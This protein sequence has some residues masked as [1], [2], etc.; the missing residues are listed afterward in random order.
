MAWPSNSS[1][2]SWDKTALTIGRSVDPILWPMLCAKSQLLDRVQKD[3][4]ENDYFEWE[5]A[6]TNARTFTATSA[7]AASS[8]SGTGI[9][10]AGGVSQ[11]QVGAIIRNSS[12]ATPIGTYLVDEI[13]QV[14]ANSGTA[15]TVT[16]DYAQQNAGSG[17]SA[18]VG[19]DTF[20]VLYTPKEEG[21]SPNVNKYKDVSITG[22]YTN[23]LDFYLTVTGTQ[24]HSK[25]MIAADNMARQFADR[26][27]ELTFDMESMAI[28]GALNNGANA[29][30]TSYV[31]TTKGLVNF[32]AVAGGNVDYTTK[33]VTEDGINTQMATLQTNGVDMTDPFLFVAHPTVCR[34]VSA[35][36]A[37]KVRVTQQE[38]S[39]GRVIK[40][41]ETDLGVS[42]EI[43]PTLACSTHDAFIVD[44]KKLFVMTLRPFQQFEWG[45]DT[46]TPDGTDAYKQR[47][48]GELGV[49]VVDGSK[50]HAYIS[51]IS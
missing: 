41:Y 31:R 11:V 47:Y 44:A 16:R 3:T 39:Y 32:V 42:I 33:D 17:S 27:V 12:R 51:S 36:G 2:S 13:M 45:I 7:T 46:G 18:H 19:T 34:K 15:L 24:L 22:N 23:I 10:V 9:T 8:S 49:K 29:G 40:S 35:F 25:R 50:G 4:T 30:S 1:T 28:Y 38:T 26:L 5:S 6:N 48:L 21:S 20:E 14:T 43:C 37:D